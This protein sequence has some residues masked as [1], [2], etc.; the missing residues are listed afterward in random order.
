D[1]E[2]VEPA[3]PAAAARQ[4][5]GAIDAAAFLDRLP[6]ALYAFGM[7]GAAQHVSPQMEELLGYPSQDWFADP[8]FYPNLLHSD[9]RERVLAEVEAG[10][11]SD[12]PFRLEYRARRADGEFVRVQDD[13]VFVRDAGGRPLHRQ[14]FLLDVTERAQALEGLQRSEER[15][16]TLLSNIPGA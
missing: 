7:D 6:L 2:S 5:P 14:G 12:R 16:R 10:S 11:S 8:A 1:P 13:A 15:F 9:D 4:V 3:G